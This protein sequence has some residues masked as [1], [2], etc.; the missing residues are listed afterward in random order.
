MKNNNNI[1][2]F[3]YLRKSG[4]G[5]DQQVQS[6]ERQQ[7]EVD[8]L[9]KRLGIT[10]LKFFSESKSAK[11]PNNRPEFTEMIK[12]ITKGEA[13][14]IVCWH[15]SRLSRNPL[16][17]GIIQQLLADRKILS[18]QTRDREYLPDD[19]QIIMSVESGGTSQYSRDLSKSVKSGL[20]RKLK[21]GIAPISA[22]L[23]YL[24]TK[25]QEHG[26][27][28]IIVDPQRFPII[29][30]MWDM[31]LDGICSPPQIRD[32][33]NKD[34]GLR[35]RVAKI[36]GGKP[37]SRST[38]YRI[39]TDPFYAGLF[40]YKG[41]LH[42]GI[43]EPMI[44][45]DEFDKVQIMLGRDGKPRPKQH[46]FTYT[47]MMT[48]G[49]CGC[50]ITA[51][52]KDKIIKTTGELKKYV[53]YYCTRRK[54]G[55]ENCTQKKVIPL[56]DLEE[57]I[58]EELEKVTISDTFKEMA[59]ELLQEDYAVTAREEQTI[60]DSQ[61]RELSVLETELKNIFQLRIGGRIDDDKF[62]METSDREKRIIRLK[63]SISEKE[64]A[65]R[66]T[67]QVTEGRFTHATKL[68]ER[69]ENGSMEEKKSIFISLG[70]NYVLKDRKL[71]INK[72]K[73]LISL[74]IKK[75]CIESP[76]SAWELATASPERKREA[77]ASL[78]PLLR[79]RWDLNPRPLP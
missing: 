23:G 4:E 56:K 59:L 31:M 73:W 64:E 71:S 40:Y 58:V 66:H 42:Q 79:S 24:N 30:K 38:I 21:N 18:I 49:E 67:I 75:E 45:M 33:A 1:R 2:Y 47:G 6:I 41:K 53:F 35:T 77:F 26:S 78:R 34:W 10:V 7:D 12:R 17:W 51:C 68:K 61:L 37:I 22:P 54:V 32:I 27:N 19:N 13:N 52:E 11:S 74:S 65:A 36:R 28:S 43:H 44:T 48:C 29:R 46:F 39:F 69:F 8:K 50:A 20:E 15:L 60:Y 55:S 72:H 62:E 5:E 70:G 57:Q 16:E 9:T 63:A 25:Q 3:G 14:G 76:I